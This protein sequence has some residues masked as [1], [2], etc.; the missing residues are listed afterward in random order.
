LRP[1]A[2]DMRL[3]KPCLLRRF[4]TE[5]WKVLFIFERIVPLRSFLQKG[6]QR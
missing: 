1:L 2:V 3:R 5:G 6:R 4:R